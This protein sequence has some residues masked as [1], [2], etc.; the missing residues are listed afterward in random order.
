MKSIK[1]IFFAL[2]ILIFFI[3]LFSCSETVTVEL[4]APQNLT[5]T[6]KTSSSVSLSWSSV[7]GASK[8]KLYVGQSK[9]F[10]SALYIG[11][12]TSTAIKITNLD[13]NTGYYFYVC[14]YS[15]SDTSDPSNSA[16]AKTIIGSPADLTATRNGSSG[17]CSV[18]LTWS[19]ISGAS[20]YILYKS[21][22]SVLDEASQIE[23]SADTNSY[24]DSEV[25]YPVT[26]YWIG[27]KTDSETSTDPTFA[28][29][30]TKDL[31][32]QFLISEELEKADSS[33]SDE[34]TS[35]TASSIAQ[36]NTSSSIS[37]NFDGN[38]IYYL[39]TSP[40]VGATLYSGALTGYSSSTMVSDTV[41]IPSISYTGNSKFQNISSCSDNSII[42]TGTI[43]P[44]EKSYVTK[45][46]STSF[47]LPI[48]RSSTL[49]RSVRTSYELGTSQN[50]WVDD[51][52]GNFEK[53]NASLMA[54]GDNCYVWVVSENYSNSSSSTGDNLV[55][56]SQVQAI[57]DLFDSIYEAETNLFGLA[58]K[59]LDS[60]SLE[61]ISSNYVNPSTKI[62]I[63]IFD[64]D[65][66]YSALQTSGT[67]GY[68]WSKDMYLDSVA[69]ANL[70]CRSNECEIFYIDC[71]FLDGYE[72]Y[73][74][75][76]LAHEFQHM[77]N[78]VNKTMINGLTYS[79]WY[80]EMLSML[81]EDIL[82]EYIN[83]SDESYGPKS[84]LRYLNAGY[85]ILGL[86]SW[87]DSTYNAYAYSNAYGFGAWLLRNYGGAQLLHEIATNSYTDLNSVCKA[88]ISLEQMTGSNSD[89]ITELLKQYSRALCYP[90]LTSSQYQTYTSESDST[91]GLKPFCSN[92]YESQT[93]TGSVGSYKYSLTPIQLSDY[94]YYSDG[95]YY[96]GPRYLS[97]SK[98]YGMSKYSVLDEYLGPVTA[99]SINYKKGYKTSCYIVVQ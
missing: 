26:Y 20:N 7:Y 84:R 30:R 6:A 62:N 25:S 78:Y 93:Y 28:Y 5:V 13:S 51:S 69:K 70:S 41:E 16:Y 8:Y 38:E 45:F 21:S 46:N 58:Y 86:E 47:D 81:C 52:D 34:R 10:S 33:T 73:I 27:C 55:N 57:A 39:A 48:K 35:I 94:S 49:D 2:S 77:L 96:A 85:Y 97:S 76:T 11:S 43:T 19:S 91:N 65:E 42:S 68:F 1:K 40:E 18:D 72:E 56:L 67:L 89:I 31:S 71:H 14:S 98:Y 24:T 4:Q 95:T 9:S 44:I 37:D 79:S 83:G 54:E 53:K 66:D 74:Y 75:S 92:A 3:I 50:F 80:T 32:Y 17:N 60:T 64:I 63:L 88:L 12:S 22:S 36:A 23:I 82:H 61:S 90:E 87:N 15:S 99:S 29:C 59:D